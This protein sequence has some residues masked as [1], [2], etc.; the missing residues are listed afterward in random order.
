MAFPGFLADYTVQTVIVG[1]SLLGLCS[2]ALGCFA[3]LRQQS[4]LGDALSHAALPGITIGFLLF[5][6][7]QL[8]ILLS[9]ALV[10]GVLAALL[11]VLLTRRSRLK[12]DAALGIAL[13]LFFAVGVV[14]L[15]HIQN[16]ENA[17]QAGLDAFLFGQ[18]AAMLRQDLWIL[19][20]VTATAL[21][22]VISFWKEF[23]VVTFDPD[24]ASSLGLPVTALEIV[25][26]TM[27]A[28][29]VVIG[30]QMVGVVLMA[31]M[32]IAP[33]AAARQWTHR[34]ETMLILAMVFGA[35]SGIT[36]ALLSSL[37]RGLATGPLIVLTASGLVLFSI[38]F[39]TR[40]GILWTAIHA[41][42]QHANLI[43]QHVLTTL[44][45]LAQNH[46]NPAYRTEQGMV[47]SY[48]G[49]AGN[50]ALSEL[51]RLGYVKPAR[52]L[53]EEG[54]HWILTAA[55]I[56]EAERILASLHPVES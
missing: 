41:R 47:V 13:S 43:T 20:T 12:T 16:R 45:Q 42:R 46:H 30:L 52:H 36:G 51:D 15:T 31:A 23:K 37:A 35:V 44:Y 40:R 56:K 26:T 50:R 14:L 55:G 19:G 39:A 54:T 4:L 9:G 27:I 25:L 7:R 2:G 21:L 11:I 34:L 29:A 24:F 22:L 1:A 3:V 18:A 17:S 48:Y 10:A 5:G 33:A 6:S 8:S 53:P 49:D 38:L 32:I 28:L